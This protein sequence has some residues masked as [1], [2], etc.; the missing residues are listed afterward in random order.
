MLYVEQSL[1]PNEEIIKTGHFHWFYTLNAAM[2]I[3]I[4]AGFMIGILY[5][6]YYW[7]VS[8]T[9]ALNFQGLP[10]HLM[11]RAWDETVAR[12]GGVLSI[13]K[14]LHIGIKI[15]AFAAFAFG[16]LSFAGMMVRKATTEICI[17]SERLILKQGVVARRVDEMSVDRIE[18]V[19]VIQGIIG[20]LVNFG[21]V[22]VR[23][24]G[25]GEV[26][27]PPIADP[28][29]FR[30]AIDHAKSVDEENKI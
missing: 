8:R 20:R 6:G 16:L 13:I 4:G 30:R 15:A 27:L 10:D 12:M 19:N 25:V 3:V 2:W 9:V 26:W 5:A 17:T 1:N 18:G 28:V 23:G 29:G 11:A 21:T 24:M 22:I 14:S 7:E